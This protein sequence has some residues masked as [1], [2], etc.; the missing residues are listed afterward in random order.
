VKAFFVPSARN[1]F[2]SVNFVAAVEELDLFDPGDAVSI[3]KLLGFE[4][5]VVLPGFQELFQ[6][7]AIG[8]AHVRP[9]LELGLIQSFSFSHDAKPAF[10]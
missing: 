1:A 4:F 9:R 6:K 3:L 10:L 7:R 5:V 8:D 2:Q